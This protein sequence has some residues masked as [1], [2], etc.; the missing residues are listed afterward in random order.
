MYLTNNDAQQK[1][2]VKLYYLLK[3]VK[4]KTLKQHLGLCVDNFML[5]YIHVEFHDKRAH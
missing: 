1:P 5:I 4:I 3:L 2:L